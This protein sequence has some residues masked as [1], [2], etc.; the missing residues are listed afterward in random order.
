MRI[1]TK[2][3]EETQALASQIAGQYKIKG[4]VIALS[5]D[6]G[7]GKTT[8]T[9]GFAKALGIDDKIISPTFVLIRQHQIPHT[10]RML[11][12]IDLYRLE[13]TIDL[14]ITGLKELFEDEENIV[15]IEWSEKISDQLP[16]NILRIHLN[17]INENEREIRIEENS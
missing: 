5:G 6:L 15:L 11:Y 17:R 14:S 8:F 12:H 1:I 10:K 13:G 7:A 4:G 9:Q 16:K 3:A 2:S